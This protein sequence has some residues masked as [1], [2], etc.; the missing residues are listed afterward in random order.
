MSDAEIKALDVLA[1]IL[2]HLENGNQIHPEALLFEDDRTV[3][4]HVREA[5]ML[6]DE[7]LNPREL[8]PVVPR[9]QRPRINYSVYTGWSGWIGKRK[10]ATFELNEERARKWLTDQENLIGL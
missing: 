4:G 5:V 9:S 2:E 6:L 1:A 10:I 8:Q 7:R 3:I